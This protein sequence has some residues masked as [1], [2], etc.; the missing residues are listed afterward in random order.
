MHHQIKKN[1]LTPVF[2]GNE[3]VI[4][5]CFCTESALP[6]EMDE[7]DEDIFNKILKVNKGNATKFLSKR[8]LSLLLFWGWC[9]RYDVLPQSLQML[10]PSYTPLW[11]RYHWDYS[12]V[13]WS[14]TVSQNYCVSTE[15]APRCGGNWNYS[16]NFF[17]FSF[18][19][20]CH[21]LDIKRK[22]GYLYALIFKC[23][24]FF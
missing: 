9:G 3:E 24:F 20:L 1:V 18:Q 23:L 22:C 2:P 7:E 17:S 10:F 8:D 15:G 5:L 14:P 21:S 19:H 16:D 12:V 6:T 4:L 13:C 11:K